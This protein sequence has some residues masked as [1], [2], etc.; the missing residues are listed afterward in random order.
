LPPLLHPDEVV[1]EGEMAFVA[2]AVAAGEA[3]LPGRARVVVD[4][5]I[6]D[7]LLW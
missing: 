2:E 6:Q 7:R 5:V 4:R 1:V 3:H